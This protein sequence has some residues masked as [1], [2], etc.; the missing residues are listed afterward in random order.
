VEEHGLALQHNHFTRD[1]TALK[2]RLQCKWDRPGPDPGATLAF[3]HVDQQHVADPCPLRSD[4]D[5][6]ADLT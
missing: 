4:G 2:R 6:R 5:G 1:I 3:R